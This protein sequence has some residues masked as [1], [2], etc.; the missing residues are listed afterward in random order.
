M[1]TINKLMR[2]CILILVISLVISSCSCS[3]TARKLKTLESIQKS[4]LETE[5]A[6]EQESSSDLQ[7]KNDQIQTE[8]TRESQSETV[9]QSSTQNETQTAV[10]TETQ[11]QTAASTE[12]Q[13]D[14]TSAEDE[15]E[16]PELP[17]APEALWTYLEQNEWTD[18]SLEG[19]PNIT[20]L[21]H[22]IGEGLLFVQFY[23][24]TNSDEANYGFY[25]PSF[26]SPDLSNFP[27]IELKDGTLLLEKDELSAESIADLLHL[28]VVYRTYPLMEYGEADEPMYSLVGIAEIRHAIR[29]A[30]LL[31]EDINE[32]VIAKFFDQKTISATSDEN[33]VKTGGV[34]G[35]WGT[36]FYLQT[37]QVAPDGILRVTGSVMNFEF[38]NFAYPFEAYFEPNPWSVWDGYSLITMRLTNIDADGNWRIDESVVDMLMDY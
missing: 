38:K 7:T 4:I 29:G 12:T 27:F 21:L 6:Y 14:A 34:G 37:V 8:T 3:S 17:E 32:E 1:L 13:T 30:F 16:F 35:I 10:S 31:D 11:T 2:V 26:S 18:Y 19:M 22:S 15:P 20:T 23:N 33:L 9:I 36:Q 5:S 25:D 24:D 28:I